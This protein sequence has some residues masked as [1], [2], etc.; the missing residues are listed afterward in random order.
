MRR[1][2]AADHDDLQRRVEHGADRHREQNRARQISPG[3]A[4]LAGQMDRLF[5]AL[6]PE[7]DAPGQGGKDAVKTEGHEPA[8][9]VKV[10]RIELPRGHDADRQRGHGRLP[11]DDDDVAVG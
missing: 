3:I 5:E 6:Q 1:I 4:R 11:D 8:A 7:D 9:G 10:R 2:E